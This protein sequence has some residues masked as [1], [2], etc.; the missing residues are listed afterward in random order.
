MAVKKTASTTT[1]KP[2]VKPQAAAPT[3]EAKPEISGG[4]EFAYNAKTQEFRITG[5]CKTA[6]KH[7][8]A[9]KPIFAVNAG[10]YVQVETSDGRKLRYAVIVY[11]E[12]TVKPVEAAAPS[13]VNAEEW[14]EFQEF[15]A[16]QAAKKAAK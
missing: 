1:G 3:G 4:Y 5:T 9:G 7:T 14:A 13:G 10:K 2:A 6:I 15:K 8:A 11:E 12:P 16:W